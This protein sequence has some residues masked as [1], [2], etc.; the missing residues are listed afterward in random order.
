MEWE[1]RNLSND[2]SLEWTFTAETQHF[3]KRHLY[4]KIIYLNIY[5]TSILYSKIV[6]EYLNMY[7]KTS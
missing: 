5:F 6:F 3:K 7:S 2:G 4:L 1:C